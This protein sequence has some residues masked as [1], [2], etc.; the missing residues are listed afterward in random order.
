MIYS[1]LFQD[2]FNLKEF[3]KRFKEIDFYGIIC[4]LLIILNSILL[5]I[6]SLFYR[7]KA[8]INLSFFNIIF[9][10]LSILFFNLDHGLDFNQIKIGYYLFFINSILIIYFCRKELKTH[11]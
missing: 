11:Q 5:L 6:Y 10:L 8:V 2:Q 3:I 4:Y 1:T 7:I 9:L